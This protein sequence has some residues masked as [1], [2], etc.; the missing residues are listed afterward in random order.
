MKNKKHSVVKA[1][2]QATTLPNGNIKTH[3]VSITE[4]GREL[5][6]HDTEYTK[7]DWELIFVKS[8][9]FAKVEVEIT[10][11]GKTVNCVR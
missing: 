10:L 8:T 3:S 7:E 2:H 6:P 5:C 9:R 4:D 11:D 1:I